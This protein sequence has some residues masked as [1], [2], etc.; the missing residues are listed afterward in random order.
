MSAKWRPCCRGSL[1]V[2]FGFSL[3][4]ASDILHHKNYAQCSHWL[5]T[6]LWFGIIDFNYVYLTGTVSSVNQPLL[7]YGCRFDMIWYDMIWYD[8]IWCDVMWCDMTWHDIIMSCH[9]MSCHMISYD[10]IWYHII[11]YDIIWYD[12]KWH[13]YHITSHHIISYEKCVGQRVGGWGSLVKLTFAMSTVHRHQHS[14]STGD[15]RKCRRFWTRRW[16]VN[17]GNTKQSQN[18]Y[19]PCTKMVVSI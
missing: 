8:M 11:S 18:K 17:T 19:I 13:E 2:V 6:L 5:L 12:I 4:H 10:I 16:L 1:E 15:L 9:V 7:E 3:R 14:F